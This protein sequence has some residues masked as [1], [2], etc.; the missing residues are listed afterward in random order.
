MKGLINLTLIAFCLRLIAAIFIPVMGEDDSYTWWIL[1]IETKHNDFIYTDP[2]KGHDKL[3]PPLYAT[4]VSLLMAMFSSESIW[5]PRFVNIFSGTFVVSMAYLIAR[6]IIACRGGKVS[7]HDATCDYGTLGFGG[8]FTTW[9]QFNAFCDN[10]VDIGILQD[11]R[12]MYR[13]VDPSTADGF[14]NGTHIVSALQQKRAAQALADL[15]K[16]NFNPNLHLNEL[17]PDA[18]LYLMV[19]KTDLI[20]NST[21]FCLLGTGGIYEIESVGRVLRPLGAGANDALTAPGGNDLIAQRTVTA[22]VSLYDQVRYSTQSHFYAGT[23]GALSTALPATNNN[24]SVEIGPEPDNGDGPAQNNWSGY[25]ALSTIG[26]AGIEHPAPGFQE[27]NPYDSTNTDGM[28][29]RFHCHFTWD[30]GLH[31]HVDGVAKAV[32]I[33][34][35]V[36]ANEDFE[37]YPAP[38]ETVPRP[39]AP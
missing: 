28:G 20:C 10:L 24:R 13:E 35:A 26:G 2:W 30:Y 4:V 33:S 32:C 21:E 34:S 12:S 8:T 31:Y 25:V 15:L 6:E 14:G 1:S 17:N 36:L 27:S 16:A 7:P 11:T 38:G 19:D 37:N 29:S 22:I 23:A 39:Y 3:F 18:N 5:I 9:R